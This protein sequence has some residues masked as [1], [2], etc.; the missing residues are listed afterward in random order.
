[1]WIMM[2]NAESV[3]V[4]QMCYAEPVVMKNG[5]LCWASGCELWCVLLS[6]WL[7]IIVF[8]AEPYVV[9]HGVLF[10]ASGCESW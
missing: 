2:N 9:N 7:C 10:W 5:V 4:N 6:Q 3:V 1:M 8:Y